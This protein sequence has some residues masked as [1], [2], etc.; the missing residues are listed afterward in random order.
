M[1]KVVTVTDLCCERCAR[2]LACSLDL[3]EGILHAKANYKKN[4]IL[5]EVASSLNDEDLKN[6]VQSA[7]FEVVSV[8]ERKGLFC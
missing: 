4:N 5:V 8:S 7:G 1:K 2:R 3:R 6:A